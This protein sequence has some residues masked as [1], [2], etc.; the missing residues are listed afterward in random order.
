[1]KRVMPITIE[2]IPL[3]TDETQSRIQ[4]AYNRIFSIASQN[5]MREDVKAKQAQKKEDIDS[6]VQ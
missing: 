5:L 1:M 3:E 4:L 2:F 6:N